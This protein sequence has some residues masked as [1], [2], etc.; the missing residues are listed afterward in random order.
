MILYIE[1]GGHHHTGRSQNEE[2]DIAI[3]VPDFDLGENDWVCPFFAQT[4]SVTAPIH[5][6]TIPQPILDKINVVIQAIELLS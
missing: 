3:E 4:T 5:H 6:S 1:R 2:D